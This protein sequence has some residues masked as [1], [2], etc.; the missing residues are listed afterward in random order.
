MFLCLFLNVLSHLE[1]CVV[2]RLLEF[3]LAEVVDTLDD[4]TGDEFCDNRPNNNSAVTAGVGDGERKFVVILAP[5]TIELAVVEFGGD[6][7]N[8]DHGDLPPNN[9]NTV[10]DGGLLSTKASEDETEAVEETTGVD[11]TSTGSG[12]IVV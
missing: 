2:S 5:E 12:C 3:E 1:E 10:V 11:E 9:S 6:E 4:E 8:G 7:L